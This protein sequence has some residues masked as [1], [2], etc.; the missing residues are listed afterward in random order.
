LVNGEER[1]TAPKQNHKF[2]IQKLKRSLIDA[3][4]RY[5]VMRASPVL[6]GF[7]LYISKKEKSTWLL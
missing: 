7:S 5:L 6:V 3:D 2:A 1:N 4:S